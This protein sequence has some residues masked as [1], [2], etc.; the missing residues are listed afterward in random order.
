VVLRD[1]TFTSIFD[2]HIPSGKILYADEE[3]LHG[4]N[5]MMAEAGIKAQVR[6]EEETKGENGGS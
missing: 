5:K 4:L 3:T 6:F 2:D 1:E